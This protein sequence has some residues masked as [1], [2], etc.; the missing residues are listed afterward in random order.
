MKLKNTN[1]IL[2]FIL[3]LTGNINTIKGQDLEKIG[4]DDIFKYS[5]GLQFSSMAY[6]TKG[7]ENRR[8]P[9]FYTINANLNLTLFNVVNVP[10]SAH[11]SKSNYDYT[12]P[13]FNHFGISPSYKFLTVHA[14]YRSMQLSSYSLSGLTFLGG[15]IEVNPKDLPIKFSAMYGKFAKAVPYKQEHENFNSNNRFDRPGYR[16][17]GY[18][19]KLTVG[20][21]EQSVEFIFFKAKDDPN[22]IPDPGP[23]SGLTPKENLVIGFHTRNKITERISLQTEYS[24][25][26]L[27]RDVRLPERK[28]ETFT[29]V[30]NLGGLFTPRYS[31][32]VNGTFSGS[33]SYSAQS[34]SFGVN[35][36]RVPPGY[37]SLGTTY[38]S[39]DIENIHLN[40]QK[41]LFDNKITLS[42]NIG[43]E[44]NNLDKSL[45]NTNKRV[46]GSANCNISLLNPLNINL[47]YSNFNSNTAPVNTTFRDTF[48]YVQ[49][50]KNYGANLSYQISNNKMAHNFN[51]NTNYQNVNTLNQ[52]ATRVNNRNTKTFNSIFSYS[53]NLTPLQINL[54]SSFH[55]NYFMPPGQDK[56]IA[57]GPT[58]GGGK[59]F[60]EGKLRTR[61]NYSFQINSASGSQKNKA[62]IVRINGSYNIS[63]HHILRISLSMRSQNSNSDETEQ[64]EKS[65]KNEYKARLTY[66]FNF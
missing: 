8:D 12:K 63:T 65:I 39:N 4:K 37:K 18:G 19:G 13:T 2:I 40:V 1:I 14:G 17:M 7:M 25:S 22:S 45:Q 57:Y 60:L 28:M 11:Y 43:T 38:L 24:L 33:L 9:F 23:E 52:T 16:R 30:N 44:H 64:Q 48:R 36:K 34:F 27:S 35:Y 15:G 51:V 62:H 66:S 61:F 58:I 20:K 42:G 41:S 47:N 6:G 46:I 56:N 3:F 53:L 50:T 32:S 26:A 54:L 31:T 21:N 55:I 49:V 10:L 59:A 5:G 29:Y